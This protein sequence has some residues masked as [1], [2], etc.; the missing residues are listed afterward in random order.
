MIMRWIIAKSLRLRFIIVALAAT[1]MIVGFGQLRQMPV[2]VFPEFAPPRVEVQTP[3]LGL[4]AAEVESLITVPLEQALNGI[5]SLD[6]MRSKSVS[7]L[8][9]IEMIFD[10]GTDLMLARQLVQERLATIAPTLPT[11]AAPPFILQPLSATSRVMKIGLSSKDL[12][13]I[14]MSMLSYW[15]IRG[16]LLRVPG[17][18]NVAIWGEQIRMLQVQVEP[19]RLKQ[20][21]VSL[22]KVMTVTADALAAGIL[23]FS[24]GAHIGTGGFIDTPN[25]RL[26]VSHV[27]PIVNPADLGQ[28]VIEERNGTPLRLADVA[29]MVEDHQ[30]LIGDAVINDGP[31]I[32]LIVE[33]LPWGNT[34]DVTEGVEAAINEM[35][36]G[37]T[38]IDIDTSI[39]RPATFVETAIDNLTESLLLG[40]LLVLVVLVLFLFD[41]R[42]A[43]ISVI[44]I[45]LSLMA[46]MMV[47]AWRGTTINTMILA[48][49][50]I[51]LGAVVDDAIVDIENI[52]RRLRLARASGSAQST[53]SIILES[54]L[55]VR[56]AVVY[57]SMIEALA[58]L[59]VF[60]LTGLTGAFFRPLAF[61]YALA[62]LVSMSIA[63]VVT[64]ALS[65]ILLSWGKLGHRDSPI[66]RVL[67]R[68][69]SKV[70]TAIVRRP[71][72][73]IA[74]AACIVLAGVIV[75]PGL[76]QELLP[77]FK[78]RDVLMHWVTKPG[79]SLT[80]ERRITVAASKE[81]RAI[82]GVKN[83]GAHIGQA[84]LADEVVGVDFGENWISI[85]PS[86]DYDAT[87]AKIQKVVDGYPGLRRDVQTY[88]K[89]RTREVL[90]GS[91]DAIVIRIFGPDLKV[92][93][94]KGDEIG[95]VLGSIDGVIEE[96][97]ELITEI[98]QVEVQ[99]NLAAAQRY[100]VKPGD[101]RRAAA[102]L[103]AGEE[104]GDIFRDGQ[105][106]DVNVWARPEVRNSLT[107]IEQLPIDTPDG[108]QVP[109]GEIA[110]VRVAPTPNAIK[111]EASERRLD[112]DANVKGRDLGS[113]VNELEDRLEEVSFPLGYHAELLGEY[114]ERQDA[115]RK[116]M[117]WAVVAAGGI[118]LLLMISFKS[119][120]LALLSFFT[121]P[122]ALVGGA[123]A[124]YFRG[125]IISLGSLVGFFT[126]LGIVARNGI[127]LISHYQHL[128]KYEGEVFG[129]HL[130]V[131]GAV[132]RLAP[133]LMTALTTAL[134]L[135]PL[136]L[137][138]NVPGQE[139]EFP[140]AI[141]I[142]GGLVV[143]TVLNLFIV[144]SLYLQFGRSRRAK[145]AVADTGSIIGA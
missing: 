106:F 37:L 72:P 93:R 105:A 88:L 33:K 86:A 139:I 18:A 45:P 98:P 39:F 53:A 15:K 23:R 71:L 54:S 51:A 14:D 9:S 141:V 91:S 115:S 85:D 119:F 29:T 67:Q 110:D 120:R 10:R 16:R 99:V 56:G 92:L 36:P 65:L 26:Q 7:Q 11:W 32:M 103:V 21:Q 55:E 28:V 5:P 19:E 94:E 77:D 101:V 108:G 35:R 111:R 41:W 30:P 116:L 135:V 74:G 80:E 125:G 46:A 20:Q 144:P 126:V 83:F 118:F 48:G 102:T 69:Y 44:T 121:L 1:L 79:T 49:L 117:G 34:L 57:A 97:V 60:F 137:T 22:D 82:P 70:L 40:S 100:G 8:S 76:G 136:I 127:M 61:S 17:V 124:V 64:P 114:A 123:L 52:I 24:P 27:L 107:D 134:A 113:V 58:L 133:I 87:M 66:V 62:V 90:A 131:R 132:E 38:G 95:E 112:V 25:Q 68:V 3:S 47:L 145:L 143:A 13:V 129:P 31:G 4:S 43:L 50:I 96:H 130:V 59:P 89:E 84:L 81:L 6:V 122:M 12:S 63:L 142:L 73:G 138:G 104:V 2:D 75:V 78:E 42:S 109:L 128:E 140:M